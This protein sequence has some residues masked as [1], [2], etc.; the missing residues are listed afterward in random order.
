MSR[1]RVTARR[2]SRVLLGGATR[3]RRATAARHEG[4]LP[5]PSPVS[6]ASE[7]DEVTLDEVTVLDLTQAVWLARARDRL[8]PDGALPSL[9]LGALRRPGSQRPPVRDGQSSRSR[10]FSRHSR[11]RR[12]CRWS[13]MKYDTSSTTRTMENL[14][15]RG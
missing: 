2:L 1:A 8:K 4:G 15:K 6:R 12:F 10:P 5:L 14:L 3:I 7:S 13:L 9:K 11:G